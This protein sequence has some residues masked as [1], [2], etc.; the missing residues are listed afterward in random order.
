MFRSI[1]RTT[2]RW[3][4]DKQFGDE[5]VFHTR[6]FP[7]DLGFIWC[8]TYDPPES[9][10]SGGEGKVRKRPGSV[11]VHIV[12]PAGTAACQALYEDGKAI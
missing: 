12:T 7:S 9:S 1:I 2:F 10:P 8:F 5:K 4:T 6:L 11:A 3:I